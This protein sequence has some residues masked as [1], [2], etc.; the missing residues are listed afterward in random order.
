MEKEQ[1]IMHRANAWNPLPKGQGESLGGF[2][3]VLRVIWIH[4]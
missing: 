4:R 3:D 1:L 2:W